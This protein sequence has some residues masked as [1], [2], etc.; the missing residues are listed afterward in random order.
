M[1][2]WSDSDESEDDM[3]WEELG[4]KWQ[5]GRNMATTSNPNQPPKTQNKLKLTLQPQEKAFGKFLNKISVEK[6]EGP[7]LSDGAS[8]Q[9]ILTS[10]RQDASRVRTKDR[11]DRATVEQV[12]D[13]R[14]KMILFKMLNKG[15]IKQINGCISTGKEANVYHATGPNDEDR[16][17]KIYKTSILVFK[18]RDK[19]VTGEFR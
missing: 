16:A 9:L 17:V 10:K 5:K 7:Q 11:A 4:G 19:Y 13:P 18:D 14:T 2:E 12:L 6:Y 8:N 15:F 1:E 3:D